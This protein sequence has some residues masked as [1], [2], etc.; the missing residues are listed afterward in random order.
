MRNTG[1]LTFFIFIGIFMMNSCASAKEKT[2]VRRTGH[3]PVL[4]K[5]VSIKPGRSYEDCFELLPGQTM[6]YT[7]NATRPVDFNIH[8]HGEDRV[9]YPVNKK[10]IARLSGKIDVDRQRYY[11]EDQ[12][13]F[14]L[15]WDN[16]HGMRVGVSFKVQVK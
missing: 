4:K 13:F 9:H 14:C 5:E 15:M 3:V 10:K 2:D 1:Y 7:F 11:I 6:K 16:P 12:E 8:Y